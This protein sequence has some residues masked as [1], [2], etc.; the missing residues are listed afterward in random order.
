M[1]LPVKFNN[2]PRRGKTGFLASFLYFLNPKFPVS[3]HLLCLHR[4]GCVRPGRK[5]R[6]PGFS[7]RGSIILAHVKYSGIMYANIDIAPQH[8][9]LTEIFK[10]FNEGFSHD[11]PH[12][13]DTVCFMNVCINHVPG[14]TLTYQIVPACFRARWFHGVFPDR[15]S[16]TT[17]ALPRPRPSLASQCLRSR[18][19]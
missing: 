13:I 12:L 19:A 5:P 7:R 1:C 3:S 9:K 14:N 10:N 8:Y 6:R 2:E 11:V 4:S 16:K 18:I 15:T 17:V